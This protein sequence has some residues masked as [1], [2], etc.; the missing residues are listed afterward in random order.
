MPGRS[1][2]LVALLSISLLLVLAACG[3]KPSPKAVFTGDFPDPSIALVGNVYYGFATQA[4]GG[5]PAIQRIVSTDHVHWTVPAV[6]DALQALPVWADDS[7]TWSPTLTHI[8]KSYILYYSAHEAGGRHCLT[9]AVAASPADQFVDKSTK[10]MVCQAGG[11]T[12]DPS[13]FVAP[14]GQRY[15]LW[16]GPNAN[17][18]ATLFSQ[19][20]SSNGLYV[21]GKVTQLLQAKPKGWTAYNIEGPEMLLSGGKYYLF[22]S[23][24][25]YW[26]SKYAMG[27]AVCAGP[28]GP[29]V[30]HSAAKPWFATHGNARGPGGGSF[31]T[32]STG[33]LFMA[34]HAWGKVLGYNNGGIRSLWIDHVTFLSGN[35]I[36]GCFAGC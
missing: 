33:A 1:R 12:I 28:Q 19:R 27:Y 30:D 18:V 29:C 3:A 20:L 16:K 5:H 9:A 8:G 6:A 15:L 26:S 31:F 35:P 2:R 23:G 13:V 17:G 10:P 32:D 14:T 34:Y 22:Y 36:V 7:G 11:E 25:N 21:L 24:G 4:P